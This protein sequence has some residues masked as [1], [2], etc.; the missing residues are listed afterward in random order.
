M[1]SR[2]SNSLRLER[3]KRRRP[4]T[5]SAELTAKLELLRGRI[6]RSSPAYASLTEPATLNLS[7]IRTKVLEPGTTLL[8]FS[9]S[10]VANSYVFEVTTDSLRSFKL[11]SRSDI[12]A[13]A[14]RVRETLL[15]REKKQLGLSKADKD[16]TIAIADLSKMVLGPLGRIHA[17]KRLLIVTDGILDFVPFAMLPDQGTNFP[18]IASY[19]IVRIPSGSTLATMRE[20]T[21]SRHH[22]LRREIAILADPVFSA[23]DERLAVKFRSK[24]PV[25][26]ESLTRSIAETGMTLP[27]LAFSYGE[28]ISIGKARPPA[29]TVLKTGVDA[30][31]DFVASGAIGD[32][33]IVHFA[34]HGLLNTKEPAALRHR[35]VS[36][37][38]AGQAA[39]WIP[40][41]ARHLQP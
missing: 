6:R 15:A 2:F 5:R 7:E 31:R 14:R 41:A 10:D 37:R 1:R 9:L 23:Q 32:Y 12:D 33:R 29:A 27:R 25:V 11:P 13:A 22:D 36:R 35:A 18:L 3:V 28:A 4:N 24:V 21:T 34:T 39:G 20:I 30:N 40:A 26:S 16:L 38:Q 19:E 17:G 8:E